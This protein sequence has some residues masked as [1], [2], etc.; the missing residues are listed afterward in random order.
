MTLELIQ[1]NTNLADVQAKILRFQK[2]VFCEVLKYDE[3]KNFTFSPGSASSRSFLICPL[4][5]LG[6][7]EWD[8]DL[9]CLNNFISLPDTLSQNDEYFVKRVVY[10]KHKHPNRFFHIITMDTNTTLASPFP[11]KE[12]S[13]Y[14]D[15]LSKSYNYNFKE[16]DYSCHALE[17]IN[18]SGH[19]NLITSR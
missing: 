12:F 16:E 17:A 11:D 5:Q 13:S 15:Y 10:T 8:F 3:A 6:E 4:V 9:A 14:A 1:T 19:I 7:Q 2:S 18:V